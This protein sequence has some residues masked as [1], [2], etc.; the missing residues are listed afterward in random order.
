MGLWRFAP[1]GLP[2]IIEA[3]FRWPGI[4]N[5][6]VVS[7]LQR[8]YAEPRSWPFFSL[9]WSCSPAS[10]VTCCWPGT[11]PGSERPDRRSDALD[12]ADDAADDGLLI[13]V[14]TRRTTSRSERIRALALYIALA[15]VV[16]LGV[17]GIAIQLIPSTRHLYIEQDLTATFLPPFS[18][19]TRSGLTTSAAIWAG[20]S[21]PAGRIADAGL[22][23]G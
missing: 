9:S 5:R 12:T 17:V 13:L 10:R 20:G 21:W 19:G 18:Q 15:A 6:L 1:A 23:V 3:I 7:I 16:T 11:T 22:A 4:G 14:E 2:M 8:D